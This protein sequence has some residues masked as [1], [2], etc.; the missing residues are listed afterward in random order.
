MKNDIYIHIGRRIK[1]KRLE[2]GLTQSA[3]CGDKI[4]RNMLSRIE[5]G[6]AHPSLDTLLYLAKKLNTPA[7]YFLCQ[8]DTEEAQYDKAVL[9]DK[10]RRHMTKGRYDWIASLSFD[11]DDEVQFARAFSEAYCALTEIERFNFSSAHR[12]LEASLNAAKNTVY[13]QE[14]LTAEITLLRCLSGTLLSSEMP[15]P[16]IVA[17]SSSIVTGTERHTYLLAVSLYA[18]TGDGLY[19]AELLPRDSVYR[20]YLEAKFL[21]RENKY[22]EALLLLN[23]LMEKSTSSLV[24]VPAMKDA[25]HCYYET[26]RYKEAYEISK[27]REAALNK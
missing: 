27:R 14:S 20:R 5:T 16:E 13:M 1:K 17:N 23:G 4:T 8:N 24:L 9:V 26:G 25:E 2:A 19:L 15:P 21:L 6:D 22:D 12:H 18:H 7:A 10:L 3:L 11:G